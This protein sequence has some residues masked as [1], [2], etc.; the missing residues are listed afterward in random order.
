MSPIQE[1][2]EENLDSGSSQGGENNPTSTKAT[3][4][5]QVRCGVKH[6]ANVIRNE[7]S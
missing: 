3:N 5:S 2:P 1:C 4:I 6:K 7:S